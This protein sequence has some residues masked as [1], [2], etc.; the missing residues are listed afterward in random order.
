MCSFVSAF[1][2]FLLHHFLS[3]CLHFFINHTLAG[4]LRLFGQEWVQVLSS[5]SGLQVGLWP[6]KTFLPSLLLSLP[7]SLWSHCFYHIYLLSDWRSN[8]WGTVATDWSQWNWICSFWGLPWFHDKADG[9]PGHCW[10]SSQLFQGPRRGQGKPSQY[11]HAVPNIPGVQF[12]WIAIFKHLVE[13]SLYFSGKMHFQFSQ[14]KADS[15][16]KTH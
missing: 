10:S 3:L 15:W 5:Q 13:T 2:S 12:S 11:C 6:C 9:W 7:S 14:I 1:C 8:V 4:W 16:G